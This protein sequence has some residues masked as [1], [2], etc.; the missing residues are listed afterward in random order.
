MSRAHPPREPDRASPAHGDD[1]ELLASILD[2]VDALVAASDADGRVVLFNRACRELTG[3]APAD[4]D[5]RDPLELLIPPEELAEVRQRMTGLREHGATYGENHWM[6]RDGRRRLIAWTNRLVTNPDGSPRWVI[7]TGIDV[8]DRRRA[9]HDLLAS[10]ER[11]RS[12]VEQASDGIIVSE[13]SYRIVSVNSRMCEMLGYRREQLEGMD[14]ARLMLPDDLARTPMRLDEVRLHGSLLMER[15]LRRADGSLFTAEISVRKVPGGAVSIVRDVSARV[16]VEEELRASERRLRSVIDSDLMGVVFTRLGEPAFDANDYALRLLD[17]TRDDLAAGRLSWN[18]VTRAVDEPLN[19]ATR[20]HLRT[21]GVAP[22]TERLLRR[23]DGAE[24]PVLVGG[25]ML[26]D[27][28][29]VGFLLDLRPLK[30]VEARLRTAEQLSLRA[31]RL[32]HVGTWIVDVA[33]GAAT[34]SDE[35]LRICG[36]PAARDVVPR[37]ETFALVHPDDRERVNDDFHRAVEAGEARRIEHRIV[38]PDGTVR[39]LETHVEPERDAAGTV[40]R[41]IGSAQDITERRSLEEQL[42]EAQKL[43]AIGRLA[44]GVAHD[45]NNLLTVILGSGEILDA[46]LAADDPRRGRVGEILAASRRAAAL[47]QQLLAFG[48]RQRLQPRVFDLNPTIVELQPILERLVG[49]RIHVDVDLAAVRATVRADRAQIEQVVLNLALNARD[50]MGERGRLAIATADGDAQPCHVVLTVTDTG[51]GMS[52]E[53]QAHIFEPFY[54]T[55]EVGRG[56]GL[57]LAT[58]YGVV[59]QSGGRIAV[60]SVP[61]SGTTFR[62]EL[63]C[64]EGPAESSLPAAAAPAGGSEAVLL[65]EDER[66]VRE[67]VATALRER[68]YHVVEAADGEEALRLAA[69]AHEPIDLLVTDVVMPAMGGPELARRL[70]ASRPGLRVLFVSGHGGDA[71]TAHD[72]EAAFLQKP[73][74]AEALA[75]AVREVLDGQ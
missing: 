74:G 28:T 59:T 60:T 51:A 17:Y 34:V 47:T 27:R 53:V 46:A 45:F 49:P 6:T 21:T 20:D 3:Y 35:L 56:T 67:L 70:G 4:F 15:V 33:T 10:E 40:V 36:L 12:L 61:G 69:D 14:G 71:V 30:G 44:G 29:L 42:R 63:P 65:V 22:P 7:G 55:K 37:D 26:D 19:D 43:E 72:R 39:V 9:E 62:I 41:V 18:A 57:G 16:R 52:A 24:I 64:V 54:T 13:D 38:R 32:A 23:R 5:G 66:A 1:R 8:T 2:V 48:R 25:S 58:V 75:R 11:Y 68:G 50:A 31:Q 73:F